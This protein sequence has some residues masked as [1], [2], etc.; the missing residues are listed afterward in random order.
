[1]RRGRAGLAPRWLRLGVLLVIVVA[2]AG[3]ATRLS[4]LALV[5]PS[6]LGASIGSPSTAVVVATPTTAVSPTPGASPSESPVAL[7]SPSPSLAPARNFSHGSRSRRSIA[8][9]FD[10][11]WNVP[12]CRSIVGTLLDDHVA[13]T[14]FPNAMYVREDPSFW[15]WVARQGF[16]VGSH[17]TTHHRIT[18]LSPD[19]LAE[20]LVS[21]RRIDDAALGSPSIPVLRPPFGAYDAAALRT[22]GKAGFRLVVGW[23]VDSRD[24]AARSVGEVVANSVRGTNGS[25][26]L[27][28]CGSALTPLALP[29]IIDHYRAN[30]FAFVTIPELF[31][32]PV[33]TRPYAPAAHATDVPATRLD[34]TPADVPAWNTA[35]ATGSDGRFR[36]AYEATDGIWFAEPDATGRMVR[37]LVAPSSSST[38]AMHPSLAV[39]ADGGVHVS[40]V[41]ASTNGFAAVYRER[42]GGVWAAPVL[43]SSLDAP[44]STT[45]V[46]VAPDGA[47]WVA[48]VRVLSGSNAGVWLARRT[49]AGWV[50]TRL[51][52]TDGTYLNPAL[53]FAPNGSAHV[54]TRRN[55]Y[56][57]ID[58]TIWTGADRANTVKVLDVASSAITFVAADPDGRLWLAYQPTGRAEV[59]LG[60]REASV[61]TWRST[62]VASEADLTG[63]AVTATGPCVAFE[64]ADPGGVDHAN[65]ACPK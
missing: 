39:D 55:G 60:V 3:M 31:D 41:V 26:I 23:D 24:W 28:H 10:D 20:E 17:T 32:L 57:E 19:A 5:S 15:N 54:F 30:G 4:G 1:M 61:W 12:A 18:A 27:L 38:F 43:V 25:I 58:E 45:S 65:V 37:E 52:P 16:P 49:G 40:Y 22:A 50:R 44:A 56:P 7:P 11:G 64:R 13:A 34:L 36:V 9:T 29:A 14:F 51:R 21:G 59:H 8:L 47:V 33:P 46:A 35:I 53:V 62:P 6:L 63:L 2:A 42:I 48:Y